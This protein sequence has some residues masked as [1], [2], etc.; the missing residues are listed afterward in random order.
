M[1]IH[2]DIHR[3]I[4]SD[5]DIHILIG[6]GYGYP[7]SSGYPI[8]LQAYP[9]AEHDNQNNNLSHQKSWNSKVQFTFFT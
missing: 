4:G 7:I 5:M 9:K 3:I 8:R 1:D 6:F 2:I